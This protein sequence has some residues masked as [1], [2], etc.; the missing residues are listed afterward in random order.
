MHIGLLYYIRVYSGKIDSG[1]KI[2]VIPK[3]RTDRIGRIILLHANKKEDIDS[4]SV[5]EIGAVVG[6]KDCKTGY[7]LTDAD[8]PIA[9]EPMAFPDPVVFVAI[10]PKTKFDEEKLQTSLQFL[11]DEDPTFKVRTDEETAQRIISGMGELHLDIIVERLR[12]EFGVVCNVSKPHVSY[13]ETITEKVS[14]EGRFIKQTGGRGQF[15]VVTLAIEPLSRGEGIKV[16]NKLRMGVIP[17]EFIPAIEEG[18]REQAEIGVLAGYPVIDVAVNILNGQYHQIDSSE[19]AFKIASA[20][21]FREAFMKGNPILLEPI[22]SLEIVVAEDFLGN[23][24]N[25]LNGREGKIQNI[26]QQKKEYMVH[27]QLPLAHSFG[28]ATDL[29]S[30]TQGRASYTMQFSHF[31]SLPKEEQNKIVMPFKI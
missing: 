1:E 29:R 15:G 12:R 31:E 3:M 24:V 25:D 19:L 10:E 26:S 28:Y 20:M 2:M 8:D 18:V 9:F 14:A 6:L 5:G 13:R 27:A 7:T 16:K 22:M 11:S 4:I 17:K 21:A 23:V 30:I